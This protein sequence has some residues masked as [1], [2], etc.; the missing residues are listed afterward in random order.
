MRTLGLSTLAAAVFTCGSQAWGHPGHG[1]TAEPN[2]VF[3][4]LSEPFHL[5]PW[6]AVAVAAYVVVRWLKS[7]PKADRS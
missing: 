1:I 5:L 3:H 6:I 7:A 4:Y 2:G